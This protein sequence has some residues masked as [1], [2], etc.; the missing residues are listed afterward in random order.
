[1]RLRTWGV[2]APKPETSINTSGVMDLATTSVGGIILLAH[3][4]T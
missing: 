1:M 2:A 3:R 4:M